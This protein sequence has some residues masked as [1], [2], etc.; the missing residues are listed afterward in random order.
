LDEPF[1][2]LDKKIRQELMDEMV[3]LLKIQKVATVMV[4]H[5]RM[6]AINLSSSIYHMED[7]EILH[8]EFLS[9]GQE[10]ID[11]DEV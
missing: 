8:R 4:T 6:E 9:P 11:A 1:A 10:K 2:N 5:H 3:G 7:G